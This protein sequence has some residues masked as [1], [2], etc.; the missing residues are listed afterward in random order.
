MPIAIFGYVSRDVVITRHNNQSIEKIGGKAYYSGVCLANLGEDTSIFIPLEEQSQDLWDKIKVKNMKIWSFESSTPRYENEFLDSSLNTRIFRAKIDPNFS[1]TSS[2]LTKNMKKELQLCDH[3][4]LAPSNPQQ[5]P[6]PFIQ[7]LQCEYHAK[8][9]AD[10]DF[11]IKSVDEN[12]KVSLVERDYLFSVLRCLDVVLLSKEDL[13]Y[14]RLV[15]NE[16]LSVISQAGPS[17]VILTKG[18]EGAIIFSKNEKKIYTI[19]AIKPKKIGDVTGAGDTYIAAYL[20]RR[21]LNNIYESA[22]F[23]ARITSLK[24]ES[25]SAFSGFNS[26]P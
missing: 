10:L 6:L 19:P 11:F 2:L 3:I 26:V 5:I 15:E 24:L 16:A 1:F 9:S 18:S 13:S 20:F 4:H 7:Y 12:G 22:L 23:A 25:S 21:K 17:E 14:F 8:L